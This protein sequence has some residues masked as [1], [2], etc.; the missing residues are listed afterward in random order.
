[1]LIDVVVLRHP[2][3]IVSEAPYKL[4]C[5]FCRLRD[6]SLSISSSNSNNHHNNHQQLHD[7][8]DDHNRKGVCFWG[9]WPNS[10]F[11]GAEEGGMMLLMLESGEGHAHLQFAHNRPIR[12]FAHAEP[13]N[14]GVRAPPSNLAVAQNPRIWGSPSGGNFWGAPLIHRRAALQEPGVLGFPLKG[15]PSPIKKILKAKAKEVCIH[16]YIYIYIYIYTYIHT[17]VRTYV[18]TYIHTYTRYM[19]SPNTRN[20]HIPGHAT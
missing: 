9:V 1:M 11:R 20:S 19:D 12:G 6:R 8:D 18:H 4:H 10:A 16:T 5:R 17:Y 7:D 15:F 14:L 13:S 2:F 3:S